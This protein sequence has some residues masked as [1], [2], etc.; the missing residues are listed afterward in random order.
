MSKLISREEYLKAFDIVI[1][2]HSQIDQRIEEYKS[3]KKEIPQ[4]TEPIDPNI[5]VFVETSSIRT[6]GLYWYS[7]NKQSVIYQEGSVSLINVIKASIDDITEKFQIKQDEITLRTFFEFGIDNMRHWRN[8]GKRKEA[9]MLNFF[10]R[11]SL[12]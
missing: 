4:N 12:I 2:Y 8:F 5:P 1:K 7:F 10:A 9:E 3:L 11:A 6:E